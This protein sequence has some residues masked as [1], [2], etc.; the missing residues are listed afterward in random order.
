MIDATI[1]SGYLDTAKSGRH[2]HY[3]FVQAE[4]DDPLNSSL[5]VWL[6]GG[7]GC[8]SLIGMMQEI[9]PYLVGNTYKQG[10]MLTKNEFRWNKVSNLLFLE[11]PA[12]V[13]FSSE[14]NATYNWTDEETA[15]DAF[16]AIHDF[17]FVKAK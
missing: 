9:G 13:G 11:S 1:Y 8:S 7:P 6:N 12:I 4:K 5:T 3:V 17:L 10:D 14:T 16:A 15:A 2:I